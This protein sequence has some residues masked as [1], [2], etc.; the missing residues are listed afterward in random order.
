[1]FEVFGPYILALVLVNLVGQILSKLQDYTVCLL[2]TSLSQRPKFNKIHQ[3]NPAEEH[4][5]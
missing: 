4:V 1:M 2:Y 3:T 5:G